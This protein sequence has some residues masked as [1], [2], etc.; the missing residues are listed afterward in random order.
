MRRFFE[1]LFVICLIV[2]A[3]E[4]FKPQNQVLNVG[5]SDVSSIVASALAQ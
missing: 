1:V 5:T 4:T 3:Y 2:V